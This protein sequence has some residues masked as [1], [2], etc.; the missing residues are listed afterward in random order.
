MSLTEISIKRPSLIIVIFSI[1]ML[2]GWYCYNL[3]SYELMPEFSQP[4]LVISTPYPGASPSDVEQSVTKKV[5]DVVSGLD[6][7][8]STLSQSY[9]GVSVIQAEFA[10]GT[11]IDEKQQ[12]AQRVINNILKDLPEEVETPSISKVTPSDAPI[13]QLTAVSDMDSRQFYDLVED[14]ILPQIQQVEGIGETNLVGGE[15]REIKVNIDREKLVF[16]QLSLSQVTN[17]I[18]NANMEFPTGKVKNRDDEMTVRLAGKFSSVEQ[19]ETLIITTPPN[20]GPIRVSDVAEVVDGAKDQSS[21]SRYNGQEGVGIIIK[22]QGDANAVEISEQVRTRITQLEQKYADKN[23]NIII[24]DDTSL[25]TLEAADAVL[26]DLMIAIILVAA[27][28]LLF[29]HSI[30]DSLIVLVAIPASLLSTFIAMYLLGYTL[31][32]MTLLAMSLV[33]GILVDDSIVVLENI[34]RHLHMGKDKIKAT[35]DGRAEIGFSA[36]AIT[37]VDVVVFAPIALINTTIGDILRQ[38]S[39]TIVVST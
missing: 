21:V 20:G 28:M 30:R 1:L 37:L 3:L 24:A 12:E 35:I 10:V 6:Q 8:K 18:N 5:E 25:F 39:I 11:D 34:H 15:V 16:Y 17:A 2:G 9:E 22:K 38:Y 36:M 26:H 7:L 19:I 14:E 31:N 27:V 4:T 23:L 33:I 13:M 29:L 32:L